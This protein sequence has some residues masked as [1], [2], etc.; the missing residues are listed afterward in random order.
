MQCV[1][2]QRGAESE[3][4]CYHTEQ[5]AHAEQNFL[6]VLYAAICGFDHLQMLLIDLLICGRNVDAL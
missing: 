6:G 4:D 5:G 1:N 2:S 3:P